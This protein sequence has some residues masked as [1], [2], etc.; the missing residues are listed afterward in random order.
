[1]EVLP[2]YI[3]FA[4]SGTDGRHAKDFGAANTV[5]GFDAVGEIVE[6]GPD[7]KHLKIGQKVATFVRMGPGTTCSIVPLAW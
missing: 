1:M 3:V 6:L 7:V 4:M 5:L 2:L